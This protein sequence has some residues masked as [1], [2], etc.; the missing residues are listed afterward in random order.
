MNGLKDKKELKMKSTYDETTRGQNWK[1]Q[2]ISNGQT[3]A[4]RHAK[5]NVIPKDE[6]EEWV[7]ESVTTFK[8]F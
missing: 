1:F 5:I 7:Q 4:I 8:E 2:M 3:Q 6:G